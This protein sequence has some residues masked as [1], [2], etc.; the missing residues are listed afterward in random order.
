MTPASVAAGVVQAVTAVTAVPFP[1]I[2]RAESA[3]ISAVTA[4]T[5][6]ATTVVCAVDSVFGVVTPACVAT[7]AGCLPMIAHVDTVPNDFHFSFFLGAVFYDTIFYSYK[8]SLFT[9]NCTLFPDPPF[10]CAIVSVF[11]V[12]TP[13]CVAAGAVQAVTTVTT[14]TS[15]SVGTRPNL[16]L[17]RVSRVC[18]HRSTSTAEVLHSRHASPPAL[19]G[20]PA[21]SPTSA[22]GQQCSSH[23]LAATRTSLTPQATKMSQGHIPT[24]GQQ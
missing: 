21:A 24:A 10:F 19:F 2:P 6:A 5:G 18:L 17:R 9:T 11:G 8:N 14:V 23:S 7:S 4:V 12:V 1:Q 22:A 20:L 16:A 3:V 13:A 15:P